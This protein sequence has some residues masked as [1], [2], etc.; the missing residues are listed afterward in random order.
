MK[1]FLSGGTH[2]DWQDRVM[3]AVAEAEFFDPRT[4]SGEAMNRIANTERR[5]LDECDVVLVYLEQS[6]PS[7]LGSAFEIGYAVANAKPVVFVDE[8]RDGHTEWLGVHCL[9]R[10][11]TLQEGI[12][13]LKGLCARNTGQER[14]AGQI[15]LPPQAI[16]RSLQAGE[17]SVLSTNPLPDVSIEPLAA[18][19]RDDEA[20]C[21]ALLLATATQAR[22]WFDWNVGYLVPYLK[23]DRVADMLQR[24]G[25]A[26]YRSEGIAWGLG[27]LGSEDER[28]ITF[29]FNVCEECKAMHCTPGP[30]QIGARCSTL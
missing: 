12:E 8:R 1:V 20:M 18:L 22:R 6:N 27:E 24:H 7:G 28:I 5:W 19:I 15:D 3:S 16:F 17:F 11:L 26:L 25:A 4:V 13:F 10:L 29:L 9:T 23:A 14:K 21:E 30:G 2:G